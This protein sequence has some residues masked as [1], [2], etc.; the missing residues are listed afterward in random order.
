LRA[1][2]WLLSQGPTER[3]SKAGYIPAT[4]QRPLFDEQQPSK[5]KITSPDTLVKRQTT[6]PT[7][8]F[9]VK[10]NRFRRLVFCQAFAR[11][12][13]TCRVS[14]PWRKPSRFK[15]CVAN[16]SLVIG[17]QG[18]EAG[19]FDRP[20]PKSARSNDFKLLLHQILLK[21]L[22]PV[23]L[24]TKTGLLSR[25]VSPVSQVSVSEVSAKPK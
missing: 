2:R 4:H 9:V 6:S 25:R 24:D 1:A 15:A 3:N 22:L 13:Q 12:M 5:P 14:P 10:P 23:G 11:F 7:P 19:S 20:R 16:K 17:K 18:Q 21:L 8:V